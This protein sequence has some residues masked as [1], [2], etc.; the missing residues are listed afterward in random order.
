MLDYLQ[1]TL[2]RKFC[3]ILHLFNYILLLPVPWFTPSNSLFINIDLNE[4]ISS[5]SVVKLDNTGYFT[6]DNEPDGTEN[7]THK[8]F[9]T[10]RWIFVF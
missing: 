2:H 8:T 3:W 5:L 10:L 1:L 4:N 9:A 6:S 7:A